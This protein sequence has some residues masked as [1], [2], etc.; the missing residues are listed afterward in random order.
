MG[1]LISYNIYVPITQAENGNPYTDSCPMPACKEFGCVLIF[2]RKRL[3]EDD[4]ATYS[5]VDS[6]VTNT[7]NQIGC[8]A[9][10]KNL[11]K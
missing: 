1:M 9:A 8:E 5:A 2:A 4:P 11:S 10:N 6:G 7:A 3:G